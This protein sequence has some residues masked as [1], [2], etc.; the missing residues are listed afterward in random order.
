M[1]LTW[2]LLTFAACHRQPQP[3]ALGQPLDRMGRSL[4]SNALVE[5]LSDPSVRD[6]RKDAYNAAPPERWAEFAED[7]LP[8]LALFDGFDGVCG[9]QAMAQD[10]ASPARYQAMAQL[11]AD[12]RLWIDSTQTTC[13]EYQALERGVAGDC[14]GRTPLHDTIDVQ[15]S[16]LILGQPS[17]ID[18]AL[19]HDEVVASTSTF[20]FLAAP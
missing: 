20:P 16:L 17:G 13:A 8:M 19:D 6:P 1:K 14:G 2:T 11:L 9:N 15:A 7:F 4:T 5:T 12:D 18:D 10:S 3:P